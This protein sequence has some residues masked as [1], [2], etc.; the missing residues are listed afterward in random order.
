V[1]SAS[2]VPGGGSCGG[3]I[4][5][6]SRKIEVDTREGQDFEGRYTSS[7]ARQCPRTTVPTA[8]WASKHDPKHRFNRFHRQAGGSCLAVWVRL[9]DCAVF[10]LHSKPP[11]AIG[12]CQRGQGDACAQP[13][14]PPTPLASHSLQETAACKPRLQCI[15]TS[16]ANGPA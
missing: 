15:S 7:L 5:C 4:V 2:C 1:Y 13:L 8:Q 16:Q 14:T 6:G 11:R 12:T 9:A 3:P 10:A